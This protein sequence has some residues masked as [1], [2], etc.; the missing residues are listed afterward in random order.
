MKKLTVDDPG[1]MKIALQQEIVRSEEARYDN[2]MHGVLLA[3]SGM[4]CYDVA[5]VLGR[6]PRTVE[7]WVTR[8][9][10][11][12]F[13]GLR[14]KEGRGR[15]AI[16]GAQEVGTIEEALRKSPQDFGYTQ[17][18]WDGKLLSQFITDRFQKHVGVRQCQRLFRKLGFRFRKPRPV[19]AKANPEAQDA[20]KKTPGKEEES[21]E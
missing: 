18:G 10:E 20:Y 19:I 21:S 9:N 15:P 7:Y 16:L 3:A 5:S 6:S 1:I 2:K 4:S 11:N 13:A 12:G 8:F 14:E 17:S